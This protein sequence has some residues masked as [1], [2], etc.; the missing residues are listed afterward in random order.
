MDKIKDISGR[1]AWS[2]LVKRV[3]NILPLCKPADIYQGLTAITLI[4]DGM[5]GRHSGDIGDKLLQYLTIVQYAR[6]NGNSEV[7][8]IEIGTLFG[9]S[10][11]IKLLA[12]RDHNLSGKIICIDPMEGYYDKKKDPDTGLPIKSDIFYKN[13]DRFD[14]SKESV[15]LREFKS[16]QKEA[17]IGLEKGSFGIL[18]IDGDH[19]YEGVKQ[20]WETY[21]QYVASDGIVL[22]DDFQDHNWPGVNK[23]IKELTADLPTNWS[24]TGYLGTTLLISKSPKNT[25]SFAFSQ[26]PDDECINF[27]AQMINIGL[28]STNMMTPSSCFR[29]A[30]VGCMFKTD[31]GLSTF[32]IAKFLSKRTGKTEF[33]SIDLEASHIASAENMLKH[34]DSNLLKFVDFHCGQSLK[35][36]PK[37][38]EN[39]NKLDFVFL[40]GGAHPIVCLKEFELAAAG[41]SRNGLIVVDDLQSI[42]PSTAYKDPRPYGKGTLIYPFLLISQCLPD[43]QMDST[44]TESNLFNTFIQASK[45]YHDVQS[46]LNIFSQNPFRLIK[47]QNHSMLIWGNQSVINIMIAQIKKAYQDVQTENDHRVILGSTA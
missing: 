21:K 35:S 38:L 5:L 39:T 33:H 8:S 19:S 23:F 42:K 24:T 44:G 26:R 3:Q 41:L 32:H 7:N 22:F 6:T 4:E 37:I 46:M 30:E 1:Q 11:L 45:Q 15:E 18:M 2:Q 20:D 13:L 43:Q 9:G 29:A 25:D 10:C 34:M 12:L 17:Q 28:S 16:N 31:E 47:F 36:L 40:D 27:R 14:F